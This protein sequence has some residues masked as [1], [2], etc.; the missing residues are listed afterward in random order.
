MDEAKI[1]DWETQNVDFKHPT[2]ELVSGLVGH[3]QSK[4]RVHQM[5]IL[6]ENLKL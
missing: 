4:E 1:N 6:Q 3:Y 2:S 5:N